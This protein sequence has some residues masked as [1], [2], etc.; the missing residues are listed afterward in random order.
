MQL[1]EYVG[2][3]KSMV[4][5]QT[6]TNTTNTSEDI[7]GSQA[8]YAQGI[9]ANDGCDYYAEEH[10]ML[11]DIMSIVPELSYK[12]SSPK[13]LLHLKKFDFAFPEFA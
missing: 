7:A 10:C 11:F 12:Y 8:A 1:P 4:S 9:T 13:H 3:T 6:L 2:G 5:V